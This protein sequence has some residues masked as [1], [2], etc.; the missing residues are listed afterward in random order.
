MK[1]R[2][3][4]GGCVPWLALA[5]TVLLAATP[6]RAAGIFLDAGSDLAGEVRDTDH[7]DWIELLSFGQSF[8]RLMSPG[9]ATGRAVP[10]AVRVTKRPDRASPG[11]FQA[12][13]SGTVIPVV[14]T[15][16]IRSGPGGSRL[17]RVALSNVVITAHRTDL[18]ADGSG[19]GP[20][21]TLTL[22]YTAAAWT[23]TEI[24]GDGEPAREHRLAWDFLRNTGSSGTE[25]LRFLV[26]SLRR[27]GAALGVEWYAEAGK[28]YRILRLR[29]WDATTPF[30]LVADVAAG[31][32][33]PRAVEIATAQPLDFFLVEE[34]E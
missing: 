27:E 24:G 6:A 7:K 5:L 1:S 32:A 26:K 23:Y 21:E 12:A 14:A 30:D 8:D 33:G 18:P 2:L 31:E 9:S 22:A 19:A 3:A 11:I 34:L 20:L 10:G 13:A 29:S 28:R 15:E 25:R 17:F 4:V 16:F